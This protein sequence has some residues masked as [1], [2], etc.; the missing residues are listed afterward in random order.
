M[1]RK[2]KPSV[3]FWMEATNIKSKLRTYL[4][5]IAVSIFKVGCCDEGRMREILASHHLREHSSIPRP[6]FTALSSPVNRTMTVCFDSD[7]Y[8]IGIDTHASRCM[9]NAPHIFKDLKLEDVGEV[10]G[11]KSG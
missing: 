4:I 8:P 3:C 9:V 2:K 7:S 11:N 10:E 5:P 6:T 1:C